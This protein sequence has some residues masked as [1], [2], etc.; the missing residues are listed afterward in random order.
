MRVNNQ[1]IKPGAEQL[2]KAGLDQSGKSKTS[3]TSDVTLQSGSHASVSLSSKA[4]EISR[5]TEMAA[6]SPE[7]GSERVAALRSKIQNGSYQID[8]DQL[9]AD[10]MGQPGVGKA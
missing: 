3:S 10:I 1:V 8:H 2:Q 4:Q 5:F 6:A 9:A 7:L